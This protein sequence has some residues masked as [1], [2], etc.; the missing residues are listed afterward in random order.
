MANQI[1]VGEPISDLF[2]TKNIIT[3][4]TLKGSIQQID[5][6]TGKRILSHKFEKITDFRGDLIDAEVFHIEPYGDTIIALVHG[7]QGKNDVYFIYQSEIRKIVKGSDFNSIII[8]IQTIKNKSLI[9][10]FLSHEL[11]SIDLE[12]HSSIFSKQISPY[13]FSCFATNDKQD[14]LVSSGESGIIYLIEPQSGKIVKSISGLH[15]DNVLSIS[16]GQKLIISGGKDRRITFYN[17]ISK[18]SWFF[19]NDHFVTLVNQSKDSKY[20]TWYNDLTNT[21]YIYN[22]DAK[23][24]TRK[25]NGHSA[26]V[27]KIE[28]I[29]DHRI[30]S[31][32]EKGIIHIWSLK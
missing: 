20:T 5:L 11:M 10:G 1:D 22:I 14:M 19:R 29:E 3:I 25:Y 13:I 16:L 7:L 8:D 15:K 21:I 27:T 23:V 17:L 9:L 24:I 2:V 31:C 18:K 6:K 26:M 12:S 30:I 32:D 28:F 4:A